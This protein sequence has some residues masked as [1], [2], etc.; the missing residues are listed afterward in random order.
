MSLLVPRTA[1]GRKRW[2][3]AL[4]AFGLAIAGH[5]L[6]LGLLLFL[7]LLQLNV[8]EQLRPAPA[9]PVVLRP[10]NA[11][12]WAQNRGQKVPAAADSLA[13][14]SK[15]KEKPEEK[16]KPDAKP[17]GQVV[18]V[19]PGNQQEDPNAKYL[20]E[21]AN[22]VQKET[23]A[24]ET[25]AFYRNA[26]PQ[27]TSTTK[28]DGNGSDAVDKP[29]LSGNR[30][31]GQDDRPLKE[32]SKAAMEVPDTKARSEVAM[33]TESAEGPGPSVP[34]R[35]ETEAVKGNSNRLL[36]RQG[37]ASAEDGS[38]GRAGEPGHANLLPSASV[39]DKIT[40]AAANDHLG[41]VDEGEGTFLNTKEWKYAGFFNRVKQSVG[42]NW[43][44]GAELRLRDPS[45][46][47]Y[48]SRDRYTV[49]NVALDD[50]GRLRD[51]YVEK[52][53]GV[54][55]LDL[56][57]VKS[58]ERAQPFPNPPPG[59]VGQD[60]QVRFNFGFFLEMSGSPRLRLF[61]APN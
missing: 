21:S 29:Q 22:K 14:E 6:F 53:C 17:Q 26:M 30:G 4:L 7:S 18:A 5:A 36:M 50:Q 39:V 60:A 31:V 13:R 61:R 44:P 8:R 10:L 54:D 46:Q 43:N 34:N 57:A 28:Q 38:S 3:R 19:A 12:Q 16:K 49:V 33:K 15:A 56:E 35:T 58:F 45:G 9:K 23:R 52:S 1:E 37:S 25:T 2:P 32:T 41:D 59:L 47:I 24:K 40:G 11:Q 27:R 42:M 51:I 55:F 48:G 20:A